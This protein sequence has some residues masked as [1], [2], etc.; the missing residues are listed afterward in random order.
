MEREYIFQAFELKSTGTQLPFGLPATLF[1]KDISKLWGIESP[2]DVYVVSPKADGLRMMLGCM[3]GHRGF[4]IDRAERIVQAEWFKAEA[5]ML[6]DCEVDGKNIW[7]F[8]AIIVNGHNIRKYA[9][10][11]R[12]AAIQSFLTTQIIKPIPHVPQNCILPTRTYSTMGEFN[13]YV[14]PIWKLHEIRYALDWQSKM[15]LP[16]DGMIFTPLALP[17]V[18]YRTFDILKWKDVES[19]TVDFLYKNGKFHAADEKSNLVEFAPASE[20]A[21]V[22]LL[23]GLVYE[24]KYTNGRWIPIRIRSD[25][26]TPNAQFT[27]EQT[28]KNILENLH[29]AEVDPSRK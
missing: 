9:Y 1:R 6:L 18:T 22:A 19:H 7:I 29:L 12:L 10:N 2:F 17:V 21:T 23:N 4:L 28:M 26:T 13:L 11:M 15:G 16:C 20:S 24:C 3:K 8:D 27:I 14:K 5:D 25:K